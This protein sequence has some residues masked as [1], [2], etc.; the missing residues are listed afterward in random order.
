MQAV[1]AFTAVRPTRASAV[2]SRR[3]LVVVA[4]KPTKTK[5]FASLSNEELLGKVGGL[6]LDLASTKWTQRTRGVEEIKAG[7]NQ[8]QP[9]PEKVP[10]AHL[11]KHLRR[12]IAQCQ[13]L[14][15]QRQI[16]EGITRKQSRKIERKGD[17]A[18]GMQL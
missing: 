15:R 1:R 10:K 7:E 9:D 13:T 8:P 16:A 14:V 3:S 17:I 18:S 4:V 5:D 11:N 12:Q 2:S 6:K